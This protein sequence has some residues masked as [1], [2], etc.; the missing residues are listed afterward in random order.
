MIVRCQLLGQLP[1]LFLVHF[2]SESRASAW[3]VSS[4]RCASSAVTRFFSRKRT[5]RP[6]SGIVT[7]AKIVDFGDK[8]IAQLCRRLCSETGLRLAARSFHHGAV[9]LVAESLAGRRSI[10]RCRS[11]SIFRV[12]MASG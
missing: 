7:R 4:T 8:P 2:S 9:L 12:L 5:M 6:Y 10:D 3:N 11:G 1:S